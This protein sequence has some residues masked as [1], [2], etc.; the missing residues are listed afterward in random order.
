VL[1]ALAGASAE[2]ASLPERYAPLVY[3]HPSERLWPL[4][5][6]RFLGGS[7][8]LWAHARGC[9]DPDL[10]AARVDT[11]AL[12]AGGYAHDLSSPLCPG[13]L[14]LQP[15]DAHT[16]PY[17]GVAGEAGFFLDLGNRLRAGDASGRSWRALYVFAR[18][19]YVVYWFLYG[20]S[21]LPGGE[22]LVHEGDWEHVA[23]RLNAR[24][25][26]TRIAFFVHGEA[27]VC[28]FAAVAKSGGTHPV[29]YSALGSHASLPGAGEHESGDVTA[30]GR[31]WTTWRRLADVRRQAWFGY[32]GA[33]GEVGANAVTTG[34]LGPSRFRSPLPASW[35]LTAGCP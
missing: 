12:G 2:A 3:L 4:G 20:A 5:P 29:V 31:R 15:S 11:V 7:E 28:R 23:L 33:W 21:G 8:L 17:S 16:R 14:A 30:R 32:G 9:G 18:G 22:G 19:R 26:P 25:R 34:P 10:V 35:R 13:I 1:L 27:V 24:N 6:E